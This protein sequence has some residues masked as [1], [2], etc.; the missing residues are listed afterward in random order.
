MK[1]TRFLSVSQLRIGRLSEDIEG[2]VH[3]VICPQIG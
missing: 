3:Q 1:W 2:L